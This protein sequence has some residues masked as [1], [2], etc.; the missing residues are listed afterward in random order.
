MRIRI[1]LP[2]HLRNLAK[3]SGDEVVVDVP[4]PVT[5]GAALDALEAAYPSLLG[6]IR[7]HPSKKRR[8]FVRYY[9]NREDYSLEPMETPLPAGVLSQEEPFIV[10]GAMAGG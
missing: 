10:M 8:A 5:L 6:T 2:Y 4:E 9:A 3:V 7:D 1:L